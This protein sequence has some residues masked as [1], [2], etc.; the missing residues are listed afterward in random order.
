MWQGDYKVAD[1][2]AFAD[3]DFSKWGWNS[4]VRAQTV[5]EVVWFLDSIIFP[6]GAMYDRANRTVEGIEGVDPALEV[7]L[8]EEP[9]G[10]FFSELQEGAEA[11]TPGG[12]PPEVAPPA[13][14][15]AT[16][17]VADTTRYRIGTSDR[18]YLL[19]ALAIVSTR[20]WVVYP[21]FAMTIGVPSM[22]L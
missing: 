7:P 21:G 3:L 13:V 1:L 6:L 16:Q 8:V 20:V 10:E 19:A 17:A 5:R 18:R 14:H 12:A 4:D 15:P 11:P 22:L 9:A 2:L